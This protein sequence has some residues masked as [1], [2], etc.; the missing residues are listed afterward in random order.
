MSLDQNAAARRARLLASVRE[1]IE[2]VSGMPKS[3]ASIPTRPWLELGLD[4][5]TLTQLALAGAAIAH[6]VKVTFRQIMENYPLHDRAGRDAR[7][8]AAT[9]SRGGRPPRRPHPS[10]VTLSRA[11]PSR[12]W[13][14]L[15]AMPR[16]MPDAVRR[17]RLVGR[18]SSARSS[19]SSSLLMSAAAG[20]ARRR[21]RVRARIDGAA[22]AARRGQ[23]CRP[24]RWC[25]AARQPPAAQVPGD[26]HQT[27]A[28]E[29]RRAGRRPG[30]RTTSRRPSAPSP[31]STPRS[32]SSRRSSA[33]GSTRSSRR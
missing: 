16:P 19:T 32:T 29:R 26:R 9:R 20:R 7:R 31:A 1:L 15:A 28:Q 21:R 25:G 18:R 24:G 11:R 2:E 23:A 12:R 5:L 30:R 22:A 14:Q 3:R 6:S 17:P 10:P 4:S 8:A 27:A 33:P 13:Q